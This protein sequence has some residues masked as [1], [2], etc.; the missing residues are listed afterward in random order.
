MFLARCDDSNN[1]ENYTEALKQDVLAWSQM[2][3]SSPGIFQQDNAEPRSAHNV[4]VDHHKN[5]EPVWSSL[6]YT[7]KNIFQNLFKR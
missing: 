6:L 1:A 2:F 7:T 5:N 3:Q 4:E